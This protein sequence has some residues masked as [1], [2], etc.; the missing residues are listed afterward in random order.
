[1]LRRLNDEGGVGG[2]RHIC[3][4]YRIHE[5]DDEYWMSM[6]LIEGGELFE[7]LIAEGA[8]SEARAAVF[9][10]Q[11]AEA[12]AFMHKAGVVHGDLKPENLLLSSW[13]KEKA[14]LKVVDFGCSVILD[15]DDGGAAPAPEVH[16]TLAY[17][18]PEKLLGNSLSPDYK[19][20]VWA[21]GCILYIILTGS[22]P[23]DKT[24]TSSD[25]EISELVKSMGVGGS[26]E[27]GG[28]L[29]D[30]LAFDERTE[31][32]SPSA[33]GL[34]RSMLDPDPDSR[35]TSE[36]VRRDPWVQGLTASWDALEGI[37]GKLEQ[38]WKKEFRDGIF[39]KFG[40]A[41]GVVSNE[42]LRSVFEQIDE[43]GDGLIEVEELMKVLQGSRIKPK[44]IQEIFDAINLDHDNG[45]SLEEFRS[46]MKN[47]L[48]AEFYQKR[49]RHMVAKELQAENKGNMSEESF[50][51]AVRRL[52]NSMDLDHNG[53]LDCHELRLLLR[54]LGVDEEEISLL[55]ASVDIDKD[56]S[57]TFDEFSQVMFDARSKAV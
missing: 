31:D 30:L 50:R 49:F 27:D 6:E 38:Y 23:F 15:K 16:S 26:T 43:D 45:I 9:L 36:A 14:G 46:V 21:A 11:F 57:L 13:D 25:E 3:R 17:D 12:L 51:A 7:H 5:G 22:H 8:Y 39:R 52:F 56:G 54:K 32:L 4:M 55:V 53:S 33:I 10:R 24:G 20:D 42:Q 47:E 35:A 18:P 29:L 41:A 2:H 19:S 48:P 37:D 34:L 28:Q 1:M 44:D 40:G